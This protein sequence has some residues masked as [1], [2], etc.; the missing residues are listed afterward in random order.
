MSPA[1]GA[2]FLPAKTAHAEERIMNM[3]Q[4]PTL[5]EMMKAA[6]EGTIERVDINSEATRQLSGHRGEDSTKVASAADVQPEHYSTEHILKMA[7]AI[8]YIANTIKVADSGNIQQ[9]GKGPGA[10][11]VLESTVHGTTMEAGAAGHAIAKDRPPEHPST[12]TEEA[13]I[14]KANTGMETND[15]MHHGKQPLHPIKNQHASI[16]PAHPLPNPTQSTKEGSAEGQL[17]QENIKRLGLDKL[18]AKGKTPP[19]AKAAAKPAPKAAAKPAPAVKG[20]A[21]IKHLRKMAEDAINPSHIEAGKDNPPDFS[22]SGKDVPR[23][24]SDVSSQARSMLGSNQSA[25]DFT[26][27][28]AKADPK[29]DVDQI[30]E[31]P[32]LTRA[33]DSVLHKVLTHTGE[34]GVKISSAVPSLAG[35]TVKV[36][37]ARALL[38]N[39][40]DKVATDK[41][42]KDK[43]KKSAMNAAPS[44]PSA[45]SGFTASSLG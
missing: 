28:Q 34:A 13:Q 38:S 7:S 39:L 25:I 20:K 37:A 1:R 4:R 30:L 18:A 12:Q 41:G 29:S 24:P 23:Q 26:K 42:A 8:D 40:M 36:A 6:M 9:P 5:H 21:P 17:F 10:L 16:A 11:K 14:G 3:A 27:Q 35:D 2:E 45:A 22:E 44:S 33:G 15:G 43:Q 31:Q 19:P 32:A